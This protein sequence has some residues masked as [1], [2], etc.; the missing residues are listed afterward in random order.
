[1]IK[2]RAFALAACAATSFA[3]A[4]VWAG[5][6]EACMTAYES[7]QLQRR[8]GKLIDARA[9]AQTC[10][11]STCPRAVASDCAQW[12]SELE[13]E[14]PSIVV[15]ANDGVTDVVDVRVSVDGKRTVDRLDGRAFEVDPGPHQLVLERKNAPARTL[16]I[17]VRE[18]ERG[19]V[20]RVVFEPPGDAQARGT[21]PAA[22]AGWAFGGVAIAGLVS[23]G[24]LALV[25]SS[26][27]SDLEGCAPRC[28][29]SRVDA[30]TRNAAFADVALGV[31]VVAAAASV[32]FFLLPRTPAGSTATR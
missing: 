24:V 18:G 16:N 28:E 32:V 25:S 2:A 8:A 13:K 11:A 5:E 31:G 15:S 26:Q 7:A 4:P 20:V 19:R 1:M 17:L 23:F 21:R 29:P 27:K 9:A 22:V 10:G 6:T 3:V 12:F 14:I 30:M